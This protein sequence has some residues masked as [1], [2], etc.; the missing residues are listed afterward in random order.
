V[1]QELIDYIFTGVVL[2]V[3]KSLLWIFS[4]N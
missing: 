4:R 3:V 2:Q 1:I